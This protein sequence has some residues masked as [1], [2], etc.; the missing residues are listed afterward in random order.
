MYTCPLMT[1][2]KPPNAFFP[3]LLCRNSFSHLSVYPYPLPYF[4]H[5]PLLSPLCTYEKMSKETVTDPTFSPVDLTEDPMSNLINIVRTNEKS[6]DFDLVEAELVRRE[7]L[8]EA[9]L[10]KVT[11]EVFQVNAKNVD[12]MVK[13][14]KKADQLE[15]EEKA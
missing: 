13:L 4:C 2:P 12:L 1:N 9:R 6:A 14:K 10:E 5:P 3:V 11:D 15:E 8:W 7:E